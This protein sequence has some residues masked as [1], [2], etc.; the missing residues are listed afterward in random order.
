MFGKET[1]IVKEREQKLSQY[2]IDLL[3]WVPNIIVFRNPPPLHRSLTEFLREGADV[4]RQQ[5][6]MKEVDSKG[7]YMKNMVFDKILRKGPFGKSTLLNSS[8][9]KKHVLHKFYV[10]YQHLD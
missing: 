6:L 7:D 8:G 3:K 1:L 10:I 4:I 5:N 9:G 2:F